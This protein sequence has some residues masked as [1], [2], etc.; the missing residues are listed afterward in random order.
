MRAGGG[1]GKHGGTLP[2]L[3]VM[4][5]VVHPCLIVARACLSSALYIVGTLPDVNTFRVSGNDFLKI[6]DFI[7]RLPAFVAAV[8]ESLAKGATVRA[9]TCTPA[10]RA[11]SARSCLH[12]R[13]VSLW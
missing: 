12:V 6:T 10:L 3:N 13:P 9:C 5:V 4:G 11:W 2:W 1:V 8:N 7:L